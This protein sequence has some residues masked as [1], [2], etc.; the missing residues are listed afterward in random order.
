MP[1]PFNDT[2]QGIVPPAFGRVKR[3]CGSWQF[4]DFVAFFRP[5]SLAIQFILRPGENFEQSV[6]NAKY[7]DTPL[8]LP[9]KYLS[10]NSCLLMSSSS[11]SSVSLYVSCHVM[12]MWPSFGQSQMN[13]IL[14]KCPPSFKPVGYIGQ[15][16]PSCLDR[17]FFK[18]IDPVKFFP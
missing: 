11:G 9:G 3:F 2:K 16:W 5:L 6:Q 12:Y 8:L 13:L 10:I 1:L 17:G 18:G 7:V 15:S 14:E 4:V